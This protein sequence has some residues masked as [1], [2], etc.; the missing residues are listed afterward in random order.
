MRNRRPPRPSTTQPQHRLTLHKLVEIMMNR[1]L[2]PCSC[3]R[4]HDVLSGK[5][6]EIHRCGTHG[7]SLLQILSEHA[8]LDH[9]PE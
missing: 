4:C 6:I 5:A 2:A 1:E 8:T 7:V 9:G 3:A